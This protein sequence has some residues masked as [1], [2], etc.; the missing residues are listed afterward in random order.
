M[1]RGCGTIA[2]MEEQ[3][4]LRQAE[5]DLETARDSTETAHYEWACFQS[6]QCA[7]KALKAFLYAKGLRAIVTHSIRDLLVW[8]SKYEPE[9]AG[10][11]GQG[12]VLDTYYIATRYPNGLVST[13]IPAEYF[14]RDEAE[15]CISY[16]GS[17]L[18]TVQQSMSA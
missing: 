16:A 1:T 3:R 6:Q 2:H 18:K 14:S 15:Q 9:F 11:V 5:R 13:D 17:I 7:E 4:W 8:C 12:K 10:L